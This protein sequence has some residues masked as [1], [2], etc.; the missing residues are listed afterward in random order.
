MIEGVTSIGPS[1]GSPQLRPR[2]LLPAPSTHPARSA[3]CSFPQRTHQPHPAPRLPLVP[4][5]H[6]PCTLITD[7]AREATSYAPPSGYGHPFSGKYKLS[8]SVCEVFTSLARLRPP[9]TEFADSIRYIKLATND[10]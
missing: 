9:I 2:S 8:L 6:A 1:K 7:A 4:P 10:P 3:P 5:R